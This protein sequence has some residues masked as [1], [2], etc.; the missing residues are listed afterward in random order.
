MMFSRALALLERIQERLA[1]DR[2]SAL[3]RALKEKSVQDGATE[4]PAVLTVPPSIP[5]ISIKTP[6]ASDPVHPMLT[7]SQLPPP[8][9]PSPPLSSLTHPL[10]A[11]PESK[12]K[13][14]RAQPDTSATKSS[15]G[16]ASAKRRPRPPSG[17]VGK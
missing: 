1:L 9:P 10:P 2:G 12:R 6:P 14:K 5:D 13:P 8:L 4:K 7:P 17:G 3:S 16:K 11:K 15:H